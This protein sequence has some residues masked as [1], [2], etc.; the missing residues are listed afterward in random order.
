MKAKLTVLLSAVAIA[1][2]NAAEKPADLTG[3]DASAFESHLGHV[4]NL[5]GRLEQGMQGP[6]L[7]GATPTNIVFYVIPDMPS[8]GHYVYPEA[9]TRLMHQH[10]QLT[11]ELN[12]RAFGHHK[13]DPLF[14]I[15][16]DY[17]YMVLQNTTIERVEPQ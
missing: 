14:Q 17:Y 11:G 13:S 1:L 7:V 9:W 6:C 10:V 8:S 3:A 16:P 12:F 4:V 5:H 15:A 2:A